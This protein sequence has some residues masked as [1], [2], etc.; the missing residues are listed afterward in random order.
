MGL[1]GEGAGS[2]EAPPLA[3]TLWGAR[4]EAQNGGLYSIKHARYLPYEI[5]IT[6]WNKIN[7]SHCASPRCGTRGLPC[8]DFPSFFGCACALREAP[9][10]TG[11]TGGGVTGGTGACSCSQALRPGIVH[12]VFYPLAAPFMSL[13]MYRKLELPL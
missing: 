2:L 3:S 9:S 1:P 4:R 11:R 13:N 6:C 8:D 7:P 10:S 5:A 12:W